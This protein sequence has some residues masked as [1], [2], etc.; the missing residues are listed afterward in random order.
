MFG[1]SERKEMTF[2]SERQIKNFISNIS[3]SDLEKKE[4][5]FLKSNNIDYFFY[6]NYKPDFYDITNV[7][8]VLKKMPNG[9]KREKKY[10]RKRD[11]N[12]K[13]LNKSLIKIEEYLSNKNIHLDKG[14][15]NGT[16]IHE[17]V[18]YKSNG[19]GFKEEFAFVSFDKVL[20]EANIDFIKSSEPEEFIDDILNAIKKFTHATHQAR[21]K[22]YANY[23]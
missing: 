15:Y 20:W 16:P 22:R 9:V 5:I 3:T 1:K 2:T 8:I 14:V 13:I 12:N 17:M 11:F 10:E 19:S 18:F 21:K 23:S 4:Y 7:G 6:E